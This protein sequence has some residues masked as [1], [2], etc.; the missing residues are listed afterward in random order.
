MPKLVDCL[1]KLMSQI[2]LKGKLVML[3]GSLRTRSWKN[4]GEKSNRSQEQIKDASNKELNIHTQ[5]HKAK[6]MSHPRALGCV[7][8]A[9][10]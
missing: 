10:V 3:Q 4:E 5:R 9:R 6:F 2:S 7:R 1:E 8:M